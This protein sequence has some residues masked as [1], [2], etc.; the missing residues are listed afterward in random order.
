VY[1]D[2]TLKL[3]V[4]NNNGYNVI[5][6]SGVPAR[7]DKDFSQ[8]YNNV[9]LNNTNTNSAD[10][11]PLDEYGRMLVISYPGF[12]EAIQ[13]FVDWKNSMGIRTELVDVTTIGATAAAIKTFVDN[14]YTT[15]G[16]T[17]LLL[18]GDGPQIPTITTG[19]VGGPSDNAYGYLV[20]D[21]HYPDIF[22]G[23]FSAENVEHVNTMVQRTLEYEKEPLTTTEWLDKGFGI[24]SDQ[25]PGDDNE[26]DF[27]H[28]QNIRTD[29]IGYTF[30]SIGELYDGSQGG[31]DQ[32]GNPTPT[33]VSAEVNAGRSII[34]YVGHG[35]DNSWG[36]TGFSNTNVNSLTNNHMW[37]F[38]FS[39]A[40]VNGNFIGGT[41][42]AEAWLRAKN[43]N[44]LTG[45]VATLMSTINQSWDPPMDGQDAMNDI[46]IESDPTN[47]KCTF[48][49]ITMNGCYK[50]NE[51]YRSGG[52]EMT[53]T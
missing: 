35:S 26:M 19:N 1:T 40:C 42:F 37:P 38:I 4:V 6:R 50:M 49:G 41:C 34:N 31:E 15:N 21:D 3:K 18:V 5:S 20:G 43:T 32:S 9:F 16:L 46:M 14:Y 17:F 22:V 28:M 39:V 47:I 2:I 33:S 7:I 36:T 29:L 27:E 51:T 11:I 45:A 13:P 23:R 12:M 48:G 52:D 30:S 44:G 8:V 53:D 25:G 10:Y 24:A